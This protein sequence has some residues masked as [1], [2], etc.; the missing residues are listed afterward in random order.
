MSKGLLDLEVVLL[1]F[2]PPSG[3]LIAVRKLEV[4][5]SRLGLAKDESN[6]GLGILDM[7]GD[8][9]TDTTTGDETRPSAASVLEASHGDRAVRFVAN[10]P[11]E[12]LR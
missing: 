11:T 9:S 3:A 8:S 5:S 4:E 6:T 10:W 1:W 7:P 2:D 12:M